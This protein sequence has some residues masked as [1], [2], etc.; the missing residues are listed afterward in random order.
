MNC[1]L[2]A[3]LLALSAIWGAAHAETVYKYDGPDGT[4]YSDRPEQD[5]A[6]PAEKVQ[7]PAGPS[8]AEQR[9]AKQRVQQMQET[10][11]EME[12]SRRASQQARERQQA[13]KAPD[14]TEGQI[15]GSTTVDHRRDPKTRIPVES[16]D[17]GEH[18]IYD[19]NKRPGSN[20]GV[21]RPPVARPA[22]GR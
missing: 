15:G 18:P 22:R 13:E 6:S 4:T 9:A 12:E 17:G 21:P 8:E 19:S 16:P 20:P 3:V 5:A 14:A 2:T 7:L 1:K 10:S 11:A